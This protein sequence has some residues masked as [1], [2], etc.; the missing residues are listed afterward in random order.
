MSFWDSCVILLGRALLA[1]TLPLR[2]CA[3]RFACKTTPGRLPVSGHVVDLVTARVGAVQETLVEGDGHEVLWVST[4][5]NS[6]KQKNSCTPRGVY[7]SISSV[8]LEE[9]ASCGT[10][11]CF[12]S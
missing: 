7:G 2:Y 12:H 3:A 11:Q 8:S 1:G 4:E 6:T 9:V 5:K 10:F